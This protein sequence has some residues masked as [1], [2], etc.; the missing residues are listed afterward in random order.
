MFVKSPLKEGERIKLL[1]YGGQ[2]DEKVH[3]GGNAPIPGNAPPRVPGS[4]PQILGNV[5]H[6]PEQGMPPALQIIPVS[7]GGD[8]IKKP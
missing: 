8:V 5:L 6:L 1:S 3:S 2:N 4:M 7:K